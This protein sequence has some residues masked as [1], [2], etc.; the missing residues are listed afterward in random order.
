MGIL[1]GSKVKIVIAGEKSASS[2][3]L[4]YAMQNNIA[5]LKLQWIQDSINNG[6]ALPFHKYVI[7]TTKA[8]STPEKSSGMSTSFSQ[9]ILTIFD[10]K[11]NDG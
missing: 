9:D 1:D 11:Q 2:E 7:K 3:K 5:C 6:Y 8:T 4:K 10:K